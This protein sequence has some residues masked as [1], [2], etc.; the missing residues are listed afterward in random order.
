MDDRAEFEILPIDLLRRG[1][2]V[3]ERLCGAPDEH[4]HEKQGD[5][6][7]AAG[8]RHAQNRNTQSRSPFLGLPGARSLRTLRARTDQP[9][10]T[11]RISKAAEKD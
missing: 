2:Y 4:D 7:R 3:R 8:D 1:F 11:R 9:Q 6:L 5:V 10:R